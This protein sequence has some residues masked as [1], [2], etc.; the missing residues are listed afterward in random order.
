MTL[1]V[2]LS[3]GWPYL[4]WFFGYSLRAAAFITAVDAVVLVQA[5]IFLSGECGV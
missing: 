3:P 5:P 4:P 1:L 2:R